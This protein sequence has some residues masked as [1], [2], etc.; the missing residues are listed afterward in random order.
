[1]DILHKRDEKLT[2]RDE[3]TGHDG[4]FLQR[5]HAE[6]IVLAIVC[7]C[8]IAWVTETLEMC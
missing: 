4:P 3:K 1:M 7:S 2:A 5:L 8:G 6:S